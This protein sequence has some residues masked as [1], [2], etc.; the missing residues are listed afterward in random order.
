MEEQDKTDA[1]KEGKNA[2]DDKE[3]KEA[4]SSNETD[5]T[6]T[7][8]SD[9]PQDNDMAEGYEEAATLSIEIEGTTEEITA[10]LYHSPLGYKMIYDNERF[11]ITSDKNGLDNYIAENLEPEKYPD[12][13]IKIS[14]PNSSDPII[15]EFE[16]GKDSIITTSGDIANFVEEVKIGSNNA[17]HYK[18]KTGEEWNSIIRNFYIIKADEN[19][20][21]IETQ[22]FLE[23]AEGFGA[24]IWAMLNTFEM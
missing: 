1:E 11:S 13:Y 2:S 15:T 22:Y 16:E 18:L 6:V 7:D 3:N 24:R 9:N 21:V 19:Y 23:A 5:E 4:T 12:V 10:S 20:Y 8:V 17:K 14:S